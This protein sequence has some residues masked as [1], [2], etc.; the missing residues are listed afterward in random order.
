MHEREEKTLITLIRRAQ[1]VLNENWQDCYTAPSAT[2]YPHQWSR[3]S[4]FI[5]IGYSYF[6]EERA[7]RELESMLRAQWADGMIPHIRYNPR[8]REEYFPDA[9]FWKP[10]PEDAPTGVDTSCI[11]QPPLLS[12]G[13]FYFYRNAVD[14]ESAKG[15][16]KQIYPALLRFHRFLYQK[17]DPHGIG[18]IAIVH[19]W[20]SAPE[21][22]PLTQKPLRQS[23]DEAEK[24]A[25]LR[26][27]GYLLELL[28]KEGYRQQRLLESSPFLVYDVLF[29]SI[30]CRANEC[31]IEIGKI[32]EEDTEELKEY[33]LSTRKAMEELLW[34]EQEGLYLSYDLRRHSRIKRPTAES[35][36]PLFAGVPSYEQAE[37]LCNYM[38]EFCRCS[39]E[40][41]ESALPE[42]PGNGNEHKPWGY[43]TGHVRVDTNWILYEGLKRYGYHH[44]A[45][46]VKESIIRL[47]TR[48]GFHEY[49]DPVRARGCGARNHSTTSALTIAIC[50]D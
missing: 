17:R 37:R 50:C 38:D 29:N 35:F 12:I 27:P 49:F 7:K 10:L 34:D 42:H 26:N 1:E 8:Y 30:L 45:M 14:M 15:F 39:I 46:D 16:L 28:R 2:G 22:S 48:Y 24:D 13:A 9:S 47:V 6:H 40:G 11:T 41:A 33:L 43:W 20:E 4:G 23:R 18:L 3:D 32:V 36:S 31:L 25:P 5:S 44:R 21:S 19:P